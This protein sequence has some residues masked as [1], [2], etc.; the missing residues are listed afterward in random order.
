MSEGFALCEPIWADGRLVDYRIIEINP[1]LQAMLGVGPEAAGT[2]LSDGPIYRPW[3]EVC[4]R[5]LVKGEP[6][7][8]EFHNPST[9]RWHEIRLT[10]VAKDRLAQFFFD[11]TERKQAQ[12]H[13]ARLFDELNHRVKNSL[14]MVSGLLQM[15]AKDAAEPVREALAKAVAR[16]EAISE[17]HGSLYS[18]GRTTEIDFG[19]YLRALCERLEDSLLEGDRIA[20]EVKAES[21]NIPVDQAAPLGMIVNELVTNAAK[22]AYPSPRSGVV[23]VSLGREADDLVLSVRDWGRGTPPAEATEPR[24]L[25]MKL[26][27]SLARQVGATMA[28]QKGPGTGFELRLPSI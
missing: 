20:I 9:N 18:G 13:Q 4:E 7:G 1:A 6:V 23:A 15:Q 19:Q 10:R 5:A 17:V 12:E 24:G 25:G 26:I 21:A 11:I 22:H 8:F 2:L 3:I 16:V 27:A 28:R 14:T